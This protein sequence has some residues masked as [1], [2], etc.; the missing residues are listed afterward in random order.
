M[1]MIV[2]GSCDDHLNMKFDESITISAGNWTSFIFKA[3]P[4]V[5]TSYDCRGQCLISP[6]PCQYVVYEP[7]TKDCFLGNF[8]TDNF[9]SLT[10]T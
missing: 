8:H 9:V 5:P 7:D 6:N 10:I 4:S 2:L 1:I 3:L